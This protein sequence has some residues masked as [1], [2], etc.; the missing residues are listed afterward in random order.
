LRRGHT[1]LLRLQMKAHERKIKRDFG[2]E[3]EE[4][5]E[6]QLAGK[7]KLKVWSQAI[8]WLALG[9]ITVALFSDPMVWELSPDHHHFVFLG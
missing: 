3:Q 5:K 6:V 1:T 9:T 7:E 8:F 2:M 4:E